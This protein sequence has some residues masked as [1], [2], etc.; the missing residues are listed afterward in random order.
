[1]VGHDEKYCN[2]GVTDLLM[3]IFFFCGRGVDCRWLPLIY[4][5]AL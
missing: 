2:E 1:M 4:E 5:V 3:L